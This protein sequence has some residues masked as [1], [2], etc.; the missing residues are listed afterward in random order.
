MLMLAL[1]RETEDLQ[2]FS[3]DEVLNVLY[4]IL[5]NEDDEDVKG[6]ITLSIAVLETLRDNGEV[7]N[8]EDIAVKS[9]LLLLEKLKPQK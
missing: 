6:A 7:D 4:D 5:K 2:H 3:I 8:T 9:Y 1:D